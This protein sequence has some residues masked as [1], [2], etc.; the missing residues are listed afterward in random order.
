MASFVD[1]N[2]T[3]SITMDTRG[4]TFTVALSG[5]YA[6]VIDLQKESGSPGSGSWIDIKSYTTANATVSDTFTVDEPTAVYRLFLTTDTSGTCTATLTNNNLGVFTLK[7]PANV[8]TLATYTQAGVTFPGTVVIDGA[9]TLTGATTLA[10][11]LTVA[12]TSIFTGSV[13][14]APVTLTAATAV[15]TIAAHASRPILLDRAGGIDVDLPTATGSGAIYE[16]YVMTTTTD[17]YELSVFDIDASGVVNGVICG[18]DDDVEFIWGSAAA[19]N[20]ITLGGSAQETG[21]TVG[22]YIRM[23]DIAA[24]V[25][26]ASG[27]IHHGT[28]TEATPFS[29]DS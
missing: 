8:T 13:L 4:D 15:L 28:G 24:S 14:T 18:V 25:Y 17:G 9:Q 10:G 29:T 20:T 7:D 1:V 16:F 21:G 23:V 11:S 2:D 22:D 19:N 3:I 5:T 26:S 12:G 27:F 6:M